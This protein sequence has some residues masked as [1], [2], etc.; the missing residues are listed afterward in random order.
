MRNFIRFLLRY[1]LF[2]LF[3]FLETISFYLL[4]NYNHHHRQTFL[5][6]SGRFAAGVLQISSTFSDY[7]SLKR[8]NEELSRENAFLRS[9]LPSPE[10]FEADQPF[11]PGQAP[12]TLNYLFR[13]AR[14]INNSVNKHHNY[15]TVNRGESHGIEAGMAEFQPGDWSVG[16]A[17]PQ[18]RSEEHTSELQSRPQ[19]VCR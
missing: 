4:V 6:S 15:L 17:T 2:F 9:Q 1:H 12:A 19:L 3:L 18:K 13:P 11:G 10:H 7:F 8:A 14:V 16:F 5:N